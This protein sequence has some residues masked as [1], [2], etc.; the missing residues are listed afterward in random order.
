MTP[1]RTRA[2]LSA[3]A[4]ELADVADG[5]EG[6]SDLIGRLIAAEDVIDRSDALVR[7]QAIDALVQRCRAL[8]D[9]AASAATGRDLDVL[10]DAVPL[11]ELA[12]RLKASGPAAETRSVNLIHTRPLPGDVH[13][14]D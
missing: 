7:A 4:A 2:L 12:G 13:L 5:I 10:L 6:L 1:D 11:A 8:G 9:V 14:F 3:F